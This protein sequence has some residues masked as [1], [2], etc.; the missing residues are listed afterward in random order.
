MTRKKN[1][2]PGDVVWTQGCESGA[3]YECRVIE[4]CNDLSSP[5][6]YLLASPAHGYAI[7]RHYSEME[8]SPR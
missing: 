2:K 1:Y 7:Y 6:E 8:R 4:P 5:G 3:W